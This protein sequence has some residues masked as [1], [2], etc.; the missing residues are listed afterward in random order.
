MVV[1]GGK[2]VG[3]SLPFLYMEGIFDFRRYP[4]GIRRYP[5]GIRSVSGRNPVVS[6]GIRWYPQVSGGIRWYPVVSGF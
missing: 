4:V 6:V 3:R 5:V 1:N 2:N